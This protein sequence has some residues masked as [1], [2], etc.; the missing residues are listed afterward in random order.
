M[1]KLTLDQREFLGN[2]IDSGML[3]MMGNHFANFTKGTNEQ[4]LLRDYFYWETSKVDK[5]VET[6]WTNGEYD[7]LSDGIRQQLNSLGEHWKRRNMI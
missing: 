4:Q 2:V 3:K 7:H 5:N 6:I 1:K